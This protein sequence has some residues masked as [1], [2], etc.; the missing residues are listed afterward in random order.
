[1]YNPERARTEGLP[2]DVEPLS[3]CKSCFTV[4]PPRSFHCSTC[5]VCVEVHDHHCPWMG[6]C[7]GLRNLKAFVC[8]LG[9]TSLHGIFT[10]IIAISFFFSQSYHQMSDLMDKNTRGSVSLVYVHLMNFACGIYATMIG[11]ML[12]C[13]ACGM[14]D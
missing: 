6:T 4:R 10:S 9:F 14:H 3:D 2:N 11:L 5:N 8:F 1:M 13:F 12:L 7:V